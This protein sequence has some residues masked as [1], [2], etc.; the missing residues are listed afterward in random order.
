MQCAFPLY[1]ISINGQ[2]QTNTKRPFHGPVVPGNAPGRG[3]SWR[4]GA[5]PRMSA[6]ARARIEILAIPGIL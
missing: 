1:C 4:I 5:T 3:V 6:E 2:S